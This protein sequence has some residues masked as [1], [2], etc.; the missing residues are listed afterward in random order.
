MNTIT[1]RVQYDTKELVEMCHNFHNNVS[2]R[3][4]AGGFM[5]PFVRRNEEGSWVYDKPCGDITESDWERLIQK[6]D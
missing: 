4:P 5:C 1:L 6:K 2:R 3:C